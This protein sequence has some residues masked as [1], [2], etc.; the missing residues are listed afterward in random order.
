[1]FKDLGDEKRVQRRLIVP[2]FSIEMVALKPER[3]L[4]Q[5]KSFVR[6]DFDG[7]AQRNETLEKYECDQKNEEDGCGF[8]GDLVACNARCRKMLA[9]FS[10]S[11]V[12]GVFEGK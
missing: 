5:F 6:S 10:K 4:G 11:G 2:N 7:G 9:V 1:M 12:A 8:A 3:C